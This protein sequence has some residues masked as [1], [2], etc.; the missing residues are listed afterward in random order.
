[1]S[2]HVYLEPLQVCVWSK[3][4]P[5]IVYMEY[6]GNVIVVWK[7]LFHH[8]LQKM[9]TTF[10]MYYS[11]LRKQENMGADI[12]SNHC[13]LRSCLVI[14]FFTYGLGYFLK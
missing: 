13:Y 4:S 12:E 3:I 7:R 5:G 11:N 14:V 10:L 9:T 8:L 6:P 1:M 2:D